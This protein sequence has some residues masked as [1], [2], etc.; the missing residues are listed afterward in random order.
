MKILRVEKEADEGGAL[1][2]MANKSF[3]IT[4]ILVITYD[5]N[6]GMGET[7]RK[8][9]STFVIFSHCDFVTSFITKIEQ[10][11]R[12]KKRK[13]MMSDGNQNDPQNPPYTMLVEQPTKLSGNERFILIEFMLF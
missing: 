12:T 4:S 2:A 9:F 3:V 1:H 5:N 8:L 10:A 11:M 7:W 6:G 13:W